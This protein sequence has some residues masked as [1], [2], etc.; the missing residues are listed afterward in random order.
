LL[1]L[2]NRFSICIQDRIGALVPR[3]KLHWRWARSIEL[4][5]DRP[6][7]RSDGPRCRYTPHQPASHEVVKAGGVC[8]YDRPAQRQGFHYGNW[9]RV[10][11]AEQDDDASAPE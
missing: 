5:E 1:A 7:D 6:G 3:R 10:V 8:D 4:R 9:M 11:F 2:S